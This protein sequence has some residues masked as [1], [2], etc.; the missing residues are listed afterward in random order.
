MMHMASAQ[1]KESTCTK[2][3]IPILCSAQYFECLGQHRRYCLREYYHCLSV[4]DSVLLGHVRNS[5]N[6]IMSRDINSYY[7]LT[8]LTLLL[9]IILS[10]AIL[11][12]ACI[13]LIVT[14]LL[15]LIIFSSILLL[16]MKMAVDVKLTAAIN[17]PKNA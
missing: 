15:L 10:V 7:L 13:V 8:L 17:A 5:S 9:Q 11:L 14:T 1:P 6:N 12:Y 3:S 2:T 16:V 4:V